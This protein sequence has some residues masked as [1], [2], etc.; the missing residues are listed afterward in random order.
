VRR[1]AS[2]VKLLGTPFLSN[3]HGINNMIKKS[4]KKAPLTDNGKLGAISFVENSKLSQYRALWIVGLQ[5]SS[6]ML[7]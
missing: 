1:N 2:K 6:R 7:K 4:P 5:N 3:Y